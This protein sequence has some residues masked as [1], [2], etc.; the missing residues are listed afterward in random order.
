MTA[1]KPWLVQ[2]VD[3]DHVHIFPALDNDQVVHDL[4]EDCVCGPCLDR[5]PRA[6]GSNGWLVIHA[7]LDGREQ[8]EEQA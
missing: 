6:D 7:S 1:Q 2:Q 8:E 4:N 5:E 3:D